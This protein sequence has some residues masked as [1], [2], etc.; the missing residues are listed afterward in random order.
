MIND[1]IRKLRK[2]ADVLEDLLDFD[3]AS[4][5]KAVKSIHK[6]IAKVNK[7]RSYNGKHWTQQPKNK[8]KLMRVVSHMKKAKGGK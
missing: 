6:S 3:P 2:A 7:K 5:I 8:A 1:L 4:N